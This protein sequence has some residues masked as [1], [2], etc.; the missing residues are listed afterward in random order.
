M[1]G[2]TFSVSKHPVTNELNSSTVLQHQCF[3]WHKQRTF[4][5]SIS[6]DSQADW[7]AGDDNRYLQMNLQ[8]SPARILYCGK[9]NGKNVISVNDIP[10]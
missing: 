5:V 3:V 4:A 8:M 6:S 10:Y 2:F 1:K 7:A 9:Q